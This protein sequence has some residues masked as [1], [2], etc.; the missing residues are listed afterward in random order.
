MKFSDMGAFLHRGN[1]GTYR[2]ALPPIPPSFL[3]DTIGHYWT[4][5]F[6]ACGLALGCVQYVQTLCHIISW[7]SWKSLIRDP[8]AARILPSVPV[9]MTGAVWSAPVSPAPQGQTEATHSLR[10]GN[11]NIS[12][13]PIGASVLI[14][15][16]TRNHQPLNWTSFNN[17]I[18]IWNDA[19]AMW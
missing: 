5:L 1:S 8:N 12:G 11:R 3:L 14:L 18:F 17:Y 13:G 10:W 19:G 7:N 2:S 16:R 4:L 9:W 6:M 15:N